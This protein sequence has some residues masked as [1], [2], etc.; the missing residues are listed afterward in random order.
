MEF[1][2]VLK[3]FGDNTVLQ[4]L[5]FTVSRGER[6]TL[7][8]PS[9]SGK[10]TILR[11]VMTLEELTGGYI[12]V[13]G[14]PLQ[15]EE[16]GGKR[17]RIPDKRRR[18]TTTD[19]GMVFQHFNLFPNMTVLENIVE[20]PIH[21]KGLSRADAVSKAEGLLAKVGMGEKRDMKPSQLSGGQQQR[22]A[23][24]RAL[25]MDPEI[26]LLDE[27]TS[28]LDPELVGEVLAVLKDIAAET[29]ISML[30]VTHEMQFARDVSDRVMMFDQ[31]SIVEE[32]PPAQIFSEPAH[33]RT[34]DFLRAVL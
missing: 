29:D 2:D 32:G 7:I 21:V 19:I 24:A 20:A 5:D 8:G 30:I 6:V 11:L 13:G 25:A 26:L 15:Y 3:R 4:G 22:V 33:Q 17:V 23:I 12:H 14:V 1:R 16:K 28:A 10:T 31:G 27:V 34:R 18:R 9:G